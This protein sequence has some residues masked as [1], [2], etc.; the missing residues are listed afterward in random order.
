MSLQVLVGAHLVPSSTAS[1]IG[2]KRCN[3][4]SCIA[5]IAL[6]GQSGSLAPWHGFCTMLTM[7]DEEA[8]FIGATAAHHQLNKKNMEGS[9]ENSSEV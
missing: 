4:S 7:P 1:Y 6:P 3:I 9:C 2:W 8:F 5:Y